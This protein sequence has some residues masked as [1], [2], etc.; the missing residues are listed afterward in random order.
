MKPFKCLNMCLKTVVCG[1][2]IGS[3]R[4]KSVDPFKNFNKNR[5]KISKKIKV[6]STLFDFGRI[7]N[8]ACQLPLRSEPYLL[9]SFCVR[10]DVDIG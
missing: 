8:S 7:K 9:Q 4:L 10:F 2:Q 5:V 3:R 6:L 1:Y